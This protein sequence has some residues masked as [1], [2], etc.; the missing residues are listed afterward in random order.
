MGSRDRV[1]SKWCAWK[2]SVGE[3]DGTPIT[4]VSGGAKNVKGPSIVVLLQ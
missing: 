4:V 3:G 1:F 2:G